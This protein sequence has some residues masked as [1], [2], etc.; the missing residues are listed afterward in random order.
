MAMYIT[1]ILVLMMSVYLYRMHQIAHQFSLRLEERVNERTRLARDLHDTLLQ[2]IQSSKMVADDALDETTDFTSMRLAMERLSRWLGQAIDEGRAALNSLRISTLQKNDLLESMKKATGELTRRS[3]LKI[4][5]AVTGVAK[6]L[7]LLLS[8]EVFLI[9]HEAIRNA[10]LHSDASRVDVELIYARDFVLRVNDDG[11]GVPAQFRD[12]G[13]QGHFGLKGMKERAAR[14]G[15]TFS[16]DSSPAT[17]T[18]IT[19]RIPGARI[20][21]KP[22]HK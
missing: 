16:L 12:G 4:E 15:G 1:L 18:R 2:T 17:G 21:R 22:T 13:K 5:F 11:K 8:E 6:E 7:D 20:F 10:C 14:I 9:G 19:L 3:S